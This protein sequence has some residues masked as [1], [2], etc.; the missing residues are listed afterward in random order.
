ML[1]L[2]GGEPFVRHDLP[3]LIGAFK[4][5]GND[6]RV[7]TNGIGIDDARIDA[8]IAAGL[9]HVS[10][11]LDTLTGR[12][13]KTSTAGRTSGMRSWAPCSVFDSVSQRRPQYRL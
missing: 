13:R 5:A 3:D 8:A 4:D 12:R 1:T 6:V 11:S 2:G 9:R 10:I 7:L